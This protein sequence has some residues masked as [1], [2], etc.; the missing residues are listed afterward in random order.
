LATTAIIPIHSGGRSIAAALKKSLRYIENPEKTD[1]GEWVT[2]YEC[3]PLVADQEFRFSKN[4]YTAVTGRSQGKN[5]VIAYHLRISFKPGE[6]DAA[7][8][9]RIGYDLAMKLTKSQYAF[10]CCTHTDKQH[11]HTHCIINS[12][13]LDCTRKFRN[14]KGSAFVIRKI[15][16]QLCLENGLSIIT[17]PELSKGKNYGKW[18][19]EGKQPSNREKLGQM[20]DSTLPACKDFEGFISDML[21]LGC[22]IKR[23]KHLSIKIPDAS[24]FI[25]TKSLGEDYTEEAIRERI[26]G[27]R[28]VS[29]K[30]KVVVLAVAPTPIYRP[31]LL[32]N[33]QAKLQQAHSPG[34]EHYVIIYNL[35]MMA[36]TLIFLQERGIGTH[37]ELDEK[38]GALDKEY[39]ERSSR[40]KEIEARQKEISELQR[41]IGTYSK[42][43]D[44]CNEY[45]RLKKIKLTAFKK[46]IKATHPADDFY[47]AH[48]A[49]IILCQAAKNY[50]NERGYGKGKKLPTIKTLKVEYAGLEK[51]KRK[52]YKGRSKQREE[53]N[54]LKMARQNVNM[55]LSEPSQ[56]TG[57][58]R[59]ELDM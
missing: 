43:K 11:I 46:M 44:S 30:E 52:L 53:V 8:A 14:F 33:I 7:T 16:D 26:L 41:Q 56:R 39:S 10:V 32:I 25:R 29:L 45:E 55:F 31:T 42:T 15:A 50:F 2:S 19:G 18:M 40:I 36:H 48:R 21:K 23:G 57:E 1:G 9:N 54:D 4:Q 12:T 49:N 24:K 13:S 27:K 28:L 34:L 37:D 6:T 22:E 3:D 38:I 51:E 47:E 59:Q 35:K 17:N 5:D 20:I 58:R